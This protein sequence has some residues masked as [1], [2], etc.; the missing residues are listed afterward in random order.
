MTERERKKDTYRGDEGRRRG[1]RQRDVQSYKPGT[2][3][4][5]WRDT[6]SSRGSNKEGH[7]VTE[8]ETPRHTHTHTHT[9]HTHTHPTHTHTQAGL[10][11]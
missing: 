2:H 5:R 6:E 8:R 9:P 3:T 11:C 4:H 7:R 1:D 10:S